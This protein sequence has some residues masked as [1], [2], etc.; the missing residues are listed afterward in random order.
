M[1]GFQ[2]FFLVFDIGSGIPLLLQRGGKG[3]NPAIV[4]LEGTAKD[5]LLSH[6]DDGRGPREGERMNAGGAIVVDSEVKSQRSKM[7]E[8]SRRARLSPNSL[9]ALCVRGHMEP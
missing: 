5:Q 9:T 1:Y 7:E 2:N 4:T 6:D 8:Q 3:S